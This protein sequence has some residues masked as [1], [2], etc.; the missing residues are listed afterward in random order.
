MPLGGQVPDSNEAALA[1]WLRIVSIRHEGR[2]L[3]AIVFS[4][5]I[6]SYTQADPRRVVAAPI[7]EQ[8]SPPCGQ[9]V[10]ALFCYVVQLTL[11]LL[12]QVFQRRCADLL[13]GHQHLL[14]TL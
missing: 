12:V 7:P 11:A 1:G 14:R 9:G 3:L 10:R 4:G 13:P 6:D 2:K 8:E 5:C